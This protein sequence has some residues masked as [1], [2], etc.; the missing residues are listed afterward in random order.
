[1]RV[2]AIQTGTVQVHERQR[3][4]AGRG[5]LRT[6]G[7]LLDREWSEPLPILAWLIEHPEGLILVDT[8]ETARALE[9]GYFPRWHPYYRLALRLQVNADEEIGPRLRQLGF[10]P[11]DVRRV[12]ITHLHTDHAGGLGWFP[13]S[14]ILISRAEYTAARGLI[15]KMRGYLPHRWPPAMSPTLIDF[16]AE[17]A[18]PF[19]ESFPLTAAGDVRLVSTAGHSAGHLSVT[20]DEGDQLLFIA[21]DT[22]YDEAALIAGT[23]DGVAAM[24]GGEAAAATAQRRIRAYARQRRLV[25]LP[26]HDAA[27]PGR[28]AERQA[29]TVG[30]EPG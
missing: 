29:V 24:G 18:G 28:L 12:V 11:D 7:T 6:L 5:P 25:Y 2:H 16:R 9:P 4:G 21:G 26:T 27:A 23:I 17:P 3:R 22:S 30:V 10:T 14:E 15:G 20:I 19:P 8:G 13:N 1:M